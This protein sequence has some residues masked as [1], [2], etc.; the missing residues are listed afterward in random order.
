M[1]YRQFKLCILHRYYIYKQ[2]NIRKGAYTHRIIRFGRGCRL[3]YLKLRTTDDTYF[4]TKQ[5]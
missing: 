1:S 2:G 5:M 3:F 4:A